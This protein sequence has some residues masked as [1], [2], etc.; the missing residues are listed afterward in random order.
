VRT[1]IGTFGGTL[2]DVAPTELAAAVTRRRLA[3]FQPL[4]IAG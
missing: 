3:Q 2:K 1:A 4:A